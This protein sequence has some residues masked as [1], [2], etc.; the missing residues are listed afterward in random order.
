MWLRDGLAKDLEGIRCIIWRYDTRL[1]KTQSFKNV[2]DIATSLASQLRSIGC[3]APSAKPFVFI[4]HSLGG[5][6]LKRALVD[7]ARSSDT[8]M[9]ILY[10][11]K[12][13]LM[14]GVPSQGMAIAHI[15][16]LVQE[17]PNEELVRI[18]EPHSS[19]LSQ[20]TICRY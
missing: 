4:A 2:D 7:M 1:S 3:N 5:I 20:P 6:V 14:F 10:K 12:A 19:F 11:I 17:Q 15:V 9:Y 13:I 16:A 8:E 18:L